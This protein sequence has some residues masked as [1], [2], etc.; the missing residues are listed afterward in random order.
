MNPDHPPIYAAVL[1]EY[2][3]PGMPETKPPPTRNPR[4]ARRRTVKR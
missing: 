4:K 3:Q 1:A 2:G